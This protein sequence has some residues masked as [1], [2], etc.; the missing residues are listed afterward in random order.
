MNHELPSVYLARH[1]ETAWTLSHQHTGRSDIPLTAR[2]EMNAKSLGERLRGVLFQKVLTSPLARARRT[3]ELAGFHERAVVDQDLTEWDYG[4]YDGLTSVEI[5]R[6][7][8]G[9]QLFRDGCPGGESVEQVGARADGVIERL[10]ATAGK[11]LVF[12]HG[13]F[14]RVLAAR[15][16]GLPADHGRLLY[17]STASLSIQ[18]YEHS[19]IEPAIHLW[20]D[21]RHVN[22]S[23]T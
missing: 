13:H 14:S 19:L 22:T 7:N 10:R 12:G 16:L 4:E 20:N 18:G 2:G 1:G 6:K 15:W 17:L 5:R 9:W 11:Q 3:C 21:D 23:T 8:P